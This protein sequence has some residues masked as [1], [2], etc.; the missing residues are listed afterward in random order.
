MRH[1]ACF[2]IAPWPSAASVTKHKGIQLTPMRHPTAATWLAA[3]PCASA[4][5]LG[6]NPAAQAG[7]ITTESIWDKKNAI[8]RAQQQLPANATVTS[9]QCTVVNVRTGNY[10]YICTLEYTTA[11]AA[12]APSS[13]SPSSGSSAPAP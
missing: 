11:P 13:T 9:S 12:P 10:R 7:S 5:L 8:E 3:I 6:F 2:Q 1:R 4:L